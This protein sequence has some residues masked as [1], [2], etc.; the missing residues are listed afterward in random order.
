[1]PLVGNDVIFTGGTVF[2]G[3]I[4]RYD[5]PKGYLKEIKKSL[6]KI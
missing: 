2:A 5:L 4:G 3:F 1:M 6:R